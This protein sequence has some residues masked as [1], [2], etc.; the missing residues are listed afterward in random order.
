MLMNDYFVQ[1]IHDARIGSFA[2]PPNYSDAIQYSTQK[3]LKS[4]NHVFESRS[5]NITIA[6]F[7]TI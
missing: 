3:Q 4:D 7:Q 6:M 2:D 5:S 1:G